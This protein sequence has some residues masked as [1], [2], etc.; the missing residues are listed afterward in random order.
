MEQSYAAGPCFNWYMYRYML[1]AS[2]FYAKPLYASSLDSDALAEKANENKPT[3]N[4]GVFPSPHVCALII[5]TYARK[6]WP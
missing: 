1:N 6:A 2:V 3:R 4:A 5:C